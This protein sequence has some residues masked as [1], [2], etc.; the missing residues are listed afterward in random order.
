MENEKWNLIRDC[1]E[2]SIRISIANRFSARYCG[3]KWATSAGNGYVYEI[4]KDCWR[5][6]KK[7]C[8]IGQSSA[9][10]LAQERERERNS[11]GLVPVQ[12]HPS[13]DSEPQTF[14]SPAVP[15]L[16]TLLKHRGCTRPNLCTDKYTNSRFVF[17]S[18]DMQCNRERAWVKLHFFSWQTFYFYE[19]SFFIIY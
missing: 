7:Y 6:K 5:K 16:Y 11:F 3:W 14:A 17:F 9:S 1:F 15:I 12:L 4:V 8:V 2:F 19:I 18:Y 13:R 10:R